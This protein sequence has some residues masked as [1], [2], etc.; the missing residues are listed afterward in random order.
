M[1]FKKII[2]DEVD[3]HL[4]IGAVL[5]VPACLL[6]YDFDLKIGLSICLVCFFG[7]IIFHKIDNKSL[8]NKWFIHYFIVNFGIFLII[9]GISSAFK[10]L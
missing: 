10:V 4:L 3:F 1:T 9:L 2:Y 8:G 6:G 7:Y 5:G